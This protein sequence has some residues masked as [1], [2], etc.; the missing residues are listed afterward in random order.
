MG[1]TK[2]PCCAECPP[3]TM[4]SP[5]S[6]PSVVSSQFGLAAP[7]PPDL[8]LLPQL[9]VTIRK[10]GFPGTGVQGQHRSPSCRV[11]NGRADLPT[12]RHAFRRVQP[13]EGNVDGLA[14]SKALHPGSE[15]SSVG[16]VASGI[17]NKKR[18]QC[19]SFEN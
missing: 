15:I 1:E 17:L 2:V 3:W 10:K 11:I 13:T 14:L 19:W 6:I 9:Q 12:C 16:K 4:V 7:L 5:H 8:D 18:E